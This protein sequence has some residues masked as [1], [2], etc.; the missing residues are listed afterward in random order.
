MKI[1][2]NSHFPHPVLSEA[3]DDFLSGAFDLEISQ[4]RESTGGEVEV[5]V[6]V[7]L[8][9]SDLQELVDNGTACTGAFIRCQDTYFSELRQANGASETWR[10]DR[11]SLHGSVE[12]KPAIWLTRPLDNWSA[13]SL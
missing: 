7:S 9:S 12:V 2:L 5:D 11:G 8:A 3:N 10:F 4:V 1:D 6:V 13:E